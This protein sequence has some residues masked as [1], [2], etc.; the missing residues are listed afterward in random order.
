[1]IIGVPPH[2]ALIMIDWLQK[3]GALLLD[4]SG[5]CCDASQLGST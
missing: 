4:A 3:K 1:M 5:Y 2:D